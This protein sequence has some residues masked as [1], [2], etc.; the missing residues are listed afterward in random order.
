MNFSS[1]CFVFVLIATT[2]AQAWADEDFFSGLIEEDQRRSEGAAA[3]LQNSPPLVLSDDLNDL[4][5]EYF[6]A[7]YEFY[8]AKYEH[9]IWTRKQKQRAH[10][11]QHYGTY[12]IYLIVVALV[13]SGLRMAW[14]QLDKALVTDGNGLATNTLE[15]SKDGVK[16]SS[17]VLGLMILAISF[18]FFY[19][20][21]DEVYPLKN[22]DGSKEKVVETIG[23]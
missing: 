7:Q 3:L 1:C 23:E 18:A 16:I 11:W 4:R 8:I 10:D 9:Y 2:T 22:E 20:F 21:I 13:G 5:A 14:K 12:V 19:L 6:R 15:V 17:P